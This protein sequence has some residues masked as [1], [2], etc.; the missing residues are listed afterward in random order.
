MIIFAV[1]SRI[2]ENKKVVASSVATKNSAETVATEQK[3][4]MYV[5]KCRSDVSSDLRNGAFVAVKESLLQHRQQRN[6]SRQLVLTDLDNL[7]QQI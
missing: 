4:R 7:S 3:S 1:V 6:F 2:L 5:M